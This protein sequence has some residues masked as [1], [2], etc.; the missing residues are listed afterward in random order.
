MADA[1][2]VGFASFSG[3]AS[4]RLTSA[5]STSCGFGAAYSGEI[6]ARRPYVYVLPYASWTW[7]KRPSRSETPILTTCESLTATTGEP[8][9]A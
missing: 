6:F 5:G 4:I 1:A 9:S 7:T 3:S 2:S 8:A